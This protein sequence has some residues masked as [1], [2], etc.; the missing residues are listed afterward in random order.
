MNI[1]DNHLLLTKAQTLLLQQCSNLAF[2]IEKFSSLDD[3]LT[4]LKVNVVIE[5][6]IPKRTIPSEIEEAVEYWKEEIKRLENSPMNEEHVEVYNNYEKALVEKRDWCQMTLRGLYDPKANVI[7]LFPEEMKQEYRGNRMDELLVSTLAHEA[8]HAYFNRPGHKRMPYVVFVEEPLA[9]FGMLLYLKNTKS[10]YYQWAYKDVRN[11]KTCYR[12]GVNLMKKHIKE[13]TPSPTRQYLEKYKFLLGKFDMPSV[14]RSGNLTLPQ[15]GGSPIA[16]N[17]RPVLAR[18]KDLF[19]YP[20]RYFYDPKTKTLGLDGYWESKPEHDTH[21]YVEIHHFAISHDVDNIYLG[22]HFFIRHDYL[23]HYILSRVPVTVSSK[24][25]D[26]IAINGIP[27]NK[28]DNEPFLSKCGDGYY[29]LYRNGKWGVIDI[30]LRTIVPFNYD[31]VWSFDEND[32]IEVEK[33]DLRGLVNKKGEEQVPVEYESISP[34][35]YDGTYTVKQ[36]GEEFNID[37]KGNRK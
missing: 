29:E 18:W 12:Y 30:K 14:N 11:K 26:F 22:D 34:I 2:Q 7:K 25:N 13:G 36:N 8:M 24:N 16:I 27:I 1:I 32:L 9:E 17:G 28:H 31:Y 19:K 6:G 3:I 10:S 33:N 21:Y 35:N 4:K 15:G 37:K 23:L 20:P 5:P